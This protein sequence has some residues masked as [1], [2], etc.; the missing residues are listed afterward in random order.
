[1]IFKKEKQF[2]R[3]NFTHKLE[4]GVSLA[5]LKAIANLSITRKAI[6]LERLM[7]HGRVDNRAKTLIKAY[8]AD[9][10]VDFSQEECDHIIWGMGHLLGA[11]DADRDTL[12]GAMI[13]MKYCIDGASEEIRDKFLHK[14]VL[15]EL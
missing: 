11:D 4:A 1:M 3:V 14:M 15:E 9:S 13:M 5:N 12:T 8:I 6:V 2:P 10:R 7:K